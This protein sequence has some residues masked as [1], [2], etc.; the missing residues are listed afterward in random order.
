MKRVLAPNGLV[1]VLFCGMKNF[2][3]SFE[4]TK[5]ILQHDRHV[6]VL[7]GDERIID[8]Q[9]RDAHVII[10]FMY[11]ITKEVLS[12]APNLRLVMQYGVGLEGVDMEAATEAGVWVSR[13]PSNVCDNA[14]SCAEHAIYLA[15]GLLRQHHAMQ[16]SLRSGLIGVPTGRTIK[17]SRALVYG[18]G[19]IG[20]Q[21]ASRLHAL[22]ARVTVIS[23]YPCNDEHVNV[24][25]SPAEFRAVAPLN[26]L[27]FI[28]TTQNKDNMGFVNADF[29]SHMKR[30]AF[31]INVAR[32]G[33][34]NYDDVLSALNSN[35]LGGVGIDVFHTEPF[36]TDDPF[37]QHERVIV[38]PHV[39][40]VTEMS[41]RQMAVITAEN[42]RNLINGDPLKYTVNDPKQRR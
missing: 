41:Y 3:S 11:P 18:Y 36:P 32:G 10:P 19:G 8:Q 4:F 17:G 34:L 14:S 30:S 2:R 42:V 31:I 29:I 22:G 13:I 23:K 27:I 21:L 9:V 12:N 5:E 33:L 35:R 7:Q 20:K 25:A 40:G 39:A 28:C 6:A 26:D 15:L 38:T 16:V 37:L 1:K 24:L